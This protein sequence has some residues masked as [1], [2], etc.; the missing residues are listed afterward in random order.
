MG[1][2]DMLFGRRSSKGTAAAHTRTGGAGDAGDKTFSLQVLFEHVPALTTDG[3]THALRSFHRGLRSATF[4][5][6]PGLAAQGTPAAQARWDERVVDFAGFDRPI[7]AE[8]LTRCVDPAHYAPALK[9]RAR[10]H[11]AHGLLFY[12]GAARDPLDRY[13]TL[14]VAA[15][16]LN[17]CSATTVL[18][19]AAHTSVPIALLQAGGDAL[20][21]L[22]ALPLLLLYCGFV[23]YEV[24]GVPGVP[25]V[26][27][28]TYGAELFGCPNLAALADS[29][30]HGQEVFERFTTILEYLRSS[31]A[32]IAA[33]HT[34]QTGPDSFSRFRAPRPEEH[35]LGDPTPVLVVE[36]I[37]KVDINR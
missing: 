18:N 31:A 19:E 28:R 1:L 10:A 27:M 16:A 36:Q 7:P 9:E 17:G 25:G 2:L 21:H 13:V 20:E 3:L 22:R 11:Q 34:M 6:A 37:S 32:Q 12:S 33:G 4:D 15:A 5:V 35:V 26:W 30:N 29:H 8:V 24:E 14:A 23:K